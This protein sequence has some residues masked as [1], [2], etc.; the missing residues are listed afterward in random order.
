[1]NRPA[2]AR[3][4]ADTFGDR[5]LRVE[6]RVER[7]ACPRSAWEPGLA[8]LLFRSSATDAAERTAL[9]QVGRLEQRA[10]DR[11]SF[12]AA[13][14]AL[15]DVAEGA[16]AGAELAQL[17]LAAHE[18]A[19]RD[20]GPPRLLGIL[21]V[22]PDS[23]SD[24]GRDSD[25]AAAIARGLALAEAGAD[26]I[27][28]GGE[29]TRPGAE[30]VS[31]AEELDRVLPVLEGL[32]KA[33]DTP[34]GIDTMKSTVAARALD[35]GA[36]MVNDVSAGRFD[37]AMIELV[38]DR[39]VRLVLMHMLGEPRTMQ[40]APDYEDPVAEVLAHLRE[41]AAVCITAGIA[42]EQLIVD[43]GIGF[44]KRLTDNLALLRGTGELRSLGLPVLVGASRKAFLAACGAPQEPSRRDGATV[45]AQTCADL[46]GADLHRVHDVAALRG[47]LGLARA[48]ATP[49]P[50]EDL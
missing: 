16:S 28:V 20:H 25:P 14:S 19:W 24:G 50:S 31:A 34:L 21:N 3:R 44:G 29:S 4:L 40:I 5:A 30:P 12:Q 2:L 33:T 27:D 35:A 23:F 45:A 9:A 26:W 43:P 41:R 13:V 32:A 1:M 36:T 10:H 49:P 6:A 11:C 17:L 15:T 46:W 38:R 7:A 48:F 47:A 8:R 39:G 18:N 22:T 42:P 37:P